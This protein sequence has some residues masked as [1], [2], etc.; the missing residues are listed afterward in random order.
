MIVNLLFV[1][2]AGLSINAANTGGVASGAEAMQDIRAG[3]V[4]GYSRPAFES[5]RLND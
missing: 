1:V 2:L 3:I 4:E 5:H